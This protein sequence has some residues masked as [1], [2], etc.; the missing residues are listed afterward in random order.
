MLLFDHDGSLSLQICSAMV[1][2]AVVNGIPSPLAF[3]IL[4]EL[5]RLF[6]FERAL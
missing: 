6:G 3:L 1:L 2:F 5:V 4:D